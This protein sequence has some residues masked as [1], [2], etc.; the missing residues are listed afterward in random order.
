MRNANT[1]RDADQHR[2]ES[3][4]AN[5]AEMLQSE[6]QHLMLIVQH[7]SKNVHDVPR[8]AADSNPS[9]KART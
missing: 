9:P 4:E 2:E 3:R 8:F 7:E 5:Q 6:L 1:E